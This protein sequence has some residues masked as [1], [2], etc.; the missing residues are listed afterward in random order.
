[1]LGSARYFLW[2]LTVP[3]DD[4][5][6]ATA[7]LCEWLPNGSRRNHGR[8]GNAFSEADFLAAMKA[9]L[10][11]EAERRRAGAPAVHAAARRPGEVRD[12]I[13]FMMSEADRA[14]FRHQHCLTAFS[15]L[16]AS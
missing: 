10:D 11:T 14:P 5:D 2:E 9:Q 12:P 16:P 3:R 6:D 15:V 13:D 4:A 7:L 1:M 8:S